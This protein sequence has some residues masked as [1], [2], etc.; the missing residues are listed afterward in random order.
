VEPKCRGNPCGCPLSGRGKPS[1]YK[2]NILA[3]TAFS[4]IFLMGKP[5][6]Y[7]ENIL[8]KKS[9]NIFDKVLM[10]KAEL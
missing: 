4:N 1:P 7:K 8:A 10:T 3:E 6:P 5:S 2:E 9:M